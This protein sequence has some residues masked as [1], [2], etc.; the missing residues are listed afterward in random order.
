MEQSDGATMFESA[1]SEGIL[2]SP[3]VEGLQVLFEANGISTTVESLKEI[4][5]HKDWD[6]EHSFT[7]NISL[8]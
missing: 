2:L 4:F 7:E 3:G 5:I 8:C 1:S 6:A